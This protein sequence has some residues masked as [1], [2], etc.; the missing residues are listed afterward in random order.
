MLT[1]YVHVRLATSCLVGTFF[2]VRLA[3]SYLVRSTFGYFILGGDLLH[4]STCIICCIA[5]VHS[6]I[7]L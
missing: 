7:V 3:T 5:G 1:V 4:S 2:I 6:V